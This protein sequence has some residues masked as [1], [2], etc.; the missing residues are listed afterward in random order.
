MRLREIEQIRE[1]QLSAQLT[2]DSE[3]SEGALVDYRLLDESSFRRWVG[4]IGGEKVLR[5]LAAR[6]APE[7]LSKLSIEYDLV[8]V[9]GRFQLDSLQARALQSLRDLNA[10]T[11]L[12]PGCGA[13]GEDFQFWLRNGI[14]NI[15]GVDFNNFRP[16]WNEFTPILEDRYQANVRC[17][18]APMEKLPLGDNSVDAVYT[19][20]T[21]EHVYNLEEGLRESFRVL[22]PGGI[23]VH[24]IG[25][26][27]Y[28]HGGDHCISSYG[29]GHGYD[30]LLLEEE[31]YRKR[32]SDDAFYSGTPDPQS[33]WWARN[34]Q[35]SFLEPKQYTEIFDRVFSRRVFTGVEISTEA[36]AFREQFPEKWGALLEAGLTE[37]TLLIKSLNL[38]CQK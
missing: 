4:R 29:L 12:V 30:H 25:P 26:L 19:T 24:S 9:G 5:V 37:E 2:V 31:E 21:L 23:A 7:I 13:C 1:R 11:V 16:T 34:D 3:T 35:L 18:I 36:L 10:P 27:F 17:F 15:I 8:G 20:A 32:V 33:H 28:T 6:I 22:R 14:R 38:L